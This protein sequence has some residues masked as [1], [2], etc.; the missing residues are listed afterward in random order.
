VLLAAV[1]TCAAR[2]VS[3]RGAGRP[4]RLVKTGAMC[5]HIQF[6][7]ERSLD[8]RGSVLK[9]SLPYV[10]LLFCTSELS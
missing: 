4:T 3:A 5:A 10:P 9:K 1:V 6:T 7:P 2:G 8:M